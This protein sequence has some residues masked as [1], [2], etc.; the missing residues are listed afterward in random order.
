MRRKEDGR[1]LSGLAGRTH[2]GTEHSTMRRFLMM[3]MLGFVGQCLR[4]SEATN[5]QETNDEQTC[6]GTFKTLRHNLHSHR[7]RE[8]D[9]NGAGAPESILPSLSLPDRIRKMF[10][11]YCRIRSNPRTES[12]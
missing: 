6:E 7:T 2:P 9:R 5:H 11:V 1:R 4:G 8:H 3:R 10:P 12:S